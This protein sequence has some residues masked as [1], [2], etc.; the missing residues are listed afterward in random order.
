MK[1]RTL[2]VASISA[3]LF[4]TL[5]HADPAPKLVG[6]MLAN[7][8]GKTLYTFDKDTAGS[9][10][11]VCNDTCAALWPPAVASAEAKD[12]KTLSVIT[13]GDGSKQ[14][15]LDGRPLYTYVQDQ[16]AGD[17]LGDGFKSVW[18]VAK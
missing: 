15:A 5:A 12:D 18:H 9:G 11:S 2:F 8:V 14:W 13:R 16:K 3:A 1:T 4:A 7:A 10:K 17:M 6:G